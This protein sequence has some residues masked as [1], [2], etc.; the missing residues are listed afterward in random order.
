MELD[1]SK[2]KTELEES[3][4]IT[5]FKYTGISEN[6]IKNYIQKLK[7][8]Q[9]NEGFEDILLYLNSFKNSNSRLAYQT[10][11]L[12]TAKHS[13]TFLKLI[14]PEV[15]DLVREQ[16][17]KLI[18]DE[19]PLSVKQIKNDH[20]EENWVEWK[21]LLKLAK[22]KLEK[23]G[24]TQDNILIG[25]YT[26]I[27]P[28]RLDFNNLLI[29][30]NDFKVEDPKQNY[31]KIK[32]PTKMVIVLQ[33]YKTS[34]TYG[35]NDIPVPA[36]LAKMIS[37]F[38]KPETIYL[39]EKN[40]NHHLPFKSPETFSRYIK[41]VFKDL[42][43]KNISVDLL[44]HFYTTYFRKGDKS[45]QEKERVAKIMGHSVATQEEYRRI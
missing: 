23:D 28:S 3:K 45:L 26:L 41:D 33:D 7:Q 20:E 16:Q 13:P 21:D 40:G 2:I 32:S 18:K 10:A 25:I 24:I 36:K 34:N 1:F 31:I 15:V 42:T 11:I 35:T 22:N 19:N 37:A 6:T 4:V 14:T 5:G 9:K 8:I 38:I 12:G 43:D 27:P 44:R 17:I 29:V 30:K 39:F